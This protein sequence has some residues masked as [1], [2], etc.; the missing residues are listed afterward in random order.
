MVEVDPLGLI[1]RELEGKYRV[2]KLAGEGGFSFV[3]RARH[4]LWDQ[5][6]ALKIF[7]LGDRPDLLDDFIR[8]GKLMSKLSSRCA[9]IVQARDVGKLDC[10]GVELPY[11][12]LEWLDGAPLDPVAPRGLAEAMELLE[13]IALALDLAHRI[14]IA[15]RDLKPDNIFLVDTGD[16]VSVKLMD[17]GIAKV[18][19]THQAL[20]EQLATTGTAISAFTPNYGAPEQF[21]RAFGATGPWT[22][23]FAMA[24]ILI[25]LMS[26]EPALEGEDFL[27]IGR[28]VCN[29]RWR[30]TPRTLGVE[31][32]DE[33]EHTFATAVALHPRDRFA[34]MGAFWAALHRALAPAAPTWQPRLTQIS[35]SELL[36]ASGPEMAPVAATLPAAPPP[37]RRTWW[38]ASAVAIATLSASAAAFALT[39]EPQVAA[40]FG[41]PAIPVVWAP[42]AEIPDE[43][44]P[45]AAPPVPS[46]AVIPVPPPA[47][48][49]APRPRPRASA[50]PPPPD[51]FDPKSFGGRR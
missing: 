51:P 2:E 3:Y 24:L 22:D 29:P 34:T 7:S 45:P 11:L 9:A 32:S 28:A 26:G 35:F 10:D 40:T 21:T 36:P 44:P 4:L 49:P 27:E 33:V 41:P 15:H 17:F 18:M 48:A 19:A 13:P 6:V 38:A 31:V 42:A 25:E 37:R 43:V 20:Q 23:V 12:V 46:P 50:E 14:G 5:P 1:G 47:V 16:G 30:P 39:C 8:E